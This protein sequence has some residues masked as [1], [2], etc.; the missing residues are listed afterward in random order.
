MKTIP[1]VVELEKALV[2]LYIERS[3]ILKSY[4]KS[5]REYINI[6]TQINMLR[7]EI[8]NEIKKAIAT[9]Q[10]ERSS[11]QTQQ[12]S[13][14]RKMV[15]LQR[16]AIE[17][18]Q[19]EK[20]LNELNRQVA[21]LHKHYMLYASKKEDAIIFSD[22]KKRNLANVSIADRA[23]IPSK[24]FYPKRVILL[25][26]SIFIGSFAALGTPF[27]LEF[28]DH[29]IKFPHDIEEMLSLPVI[30]SLPAEKY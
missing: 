22:R 30:C 4:T 27:I 23:E 13:L 9:E 28:I 16:S 10:V 26:L 11:L 1:A 25:I 21:L 3:E 17:F 2:P 29:R 18:N 8:R 5:S 20:K 24:P 14:S 7:A 19:K 12:E 15:E 6:D